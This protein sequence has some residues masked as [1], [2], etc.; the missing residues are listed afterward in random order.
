MDAFGNADK[1]G[2]I[3]KICEKSVL[4]HLRPNNIE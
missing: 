3:I 4:E 1:Y 2:F